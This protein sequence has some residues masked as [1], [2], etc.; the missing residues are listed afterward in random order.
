MSETPASTSSPLLRA[1]E[2]ALNRLLALDSVVATDLATLEGRSVALRLKPWPKPIRASVADGRFRLEDA[3]DADLS[4]VATPGALLALAGERGGLSLPAGR[5]EIAG[6]ADLARRLQKLVAGYSPDLDAPLAAAFGEVAGHQI[7]KG[8]RAAFAFGRDTLRTLTRSTAEYLRE[9]SR[10]LVAP[11]EVE[12]FIEEVDGLR[13]A[14]ERA[15]ARIQ[16]LARRRAS[17]VGRA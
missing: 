5:I 6:D 1:A 12:A 2:A 15:E 4:I 7:G 17:Q 9:E 10:D 11:G 13:D 14:V 3:R 16:R 8:L